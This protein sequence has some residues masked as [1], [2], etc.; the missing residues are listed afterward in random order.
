MKCNSKN[1]TRIRVV[2]LFQQFKI[3]N[4]EK[5]IF[6]FALDACFTNRHAKSV[7]FMCVTVIIQSR[8]L[9]FVGNS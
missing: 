7:F 4:D 1:A 8:T 6:N 5:T 2:F 3:A 9:H